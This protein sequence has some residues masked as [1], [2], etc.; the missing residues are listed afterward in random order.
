MFASPNIQCRGIDLIDEG[1]RK[2][3]PREIDSL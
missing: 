2:T 3:D 1:R